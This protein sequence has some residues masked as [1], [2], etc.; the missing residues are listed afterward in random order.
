MG[1]EASMHPGAKQVPMNQ[2]VAASLTERE[3]FLGFQADPAEMITVLWALRRPGGSAWQPASHGAGL[4]GIGKMDDGGRTET[5][6]V[7][8]PL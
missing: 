1:E 2:G 6:F 4:V 5:P 8:S 3:R 7:G